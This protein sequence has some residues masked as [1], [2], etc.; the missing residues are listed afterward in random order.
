MKNLKQF[1]LQLLLLSAIILLGN[2]IFLTGSSKSLKDNFIINLYNSN[3]ILPTTPLWNYSLGEDQQVEAVTISSDGGYIT[4]SWKTLGNTNLSATIILFNNSLPEIK[5]PLWN[6]SVLKSLYDIGI[7]AN[8]SYIVASVYFT[9]FRVIFFDYL[10]P[11]PLWNYSTGDGFSDVW[12]SDDGFYI[13]VTG[14]SEKLFL[15]NKTGSSPFWEAST[16]GSTLRVDA[17]SNASYIVTTDNAYRLY[18]FN[19]SSSVPEWTFYF[20]GYTTDALSIST[21][22]NYVATGGGAVYLF[23]KN[24]SIPIWVYNTPNYVDSIKMTPDSKYIVVGCRDRNVYFFNRLNS[25]PIWNYSTGGNIVAVDIS[26][27]G[28]YIVAQS[29]DDYV[30]L[31]NNASSIPIW[32]YKLDNVGCCRSNKLDISSDGKYIVAGGSNY[33]YLFDRDL[34]PVPQITINNPKPNITYG[35]YAPVYDITVSIPYNTIWYTIDNGVT[36]IT[37]NTLYYH[38]KQSE[39]DK[40][41]NGLVTISFY[42]NNSIGLIGE[43]YVQVFKNLHTENS[44]EIS[45]YGLMLLFGISTVIILIIIRRQKSNYA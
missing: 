18:F 16:T 24:S 3:S 29:Q 35:N 1:N 19:K 32:V 40:K 34:V 42:A 20:P 6:Y 38:I 44:P 33:I 41:E 37:I 8:G 31:F 21:D 9:D 28:E 45:G 12:I 22:G 2:P 36:N 30:Y 4:A 39:W 10:N 13:A 23:H 14:A 7:S 27:N 15:F 17:S 43:A 5:N 26:D 25:T 11:I